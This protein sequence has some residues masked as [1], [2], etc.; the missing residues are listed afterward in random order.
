MDDKIANAL[1][2]IQR[3]MRHARRPAILT[4]FGKDSMVLLFLVRDWCAANGHKMPDCIFF[5]EPHMPRK[6]AHANA[7]IEAWCLSVYDWRPSSTWMLQS[8]DEWEIM[9]RYAIG[10]QHD[11][12]CP[13]GIR[14]PQDG[15][16]FLC[17]LADIYNKPLAAPAP[18]LWD[19]LL[20]GHKG[21]D[22]DTIQG[23]DIGTR[24]DWRVV[25]G[26]PVELVFPLRT[27]DDK[28]IWEFSTA[29]NVPQN[30][31]RYVPDGQGGMQE[32]DDYTWNPDYF[33]ACTACMDRRPGA[34]THVPC[35]KRGGAMIENTSPYLRWM[36]PEKLPYFDPA[37][38]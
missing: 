30:D 32:S 34:P 3:A 18:G 28:D 31:R 11:L 4:S 37:K 1:D 13:T 27:W 36:E 14:P 5:K 22:T 2:L 16:P 26:C 20:I 12:P 9:N 29:R 35:P 6:Y 8:G 19:L 25:P 7:V 33:E 21:S 38:I 23:G 10:E 17:A 15:K 24:I